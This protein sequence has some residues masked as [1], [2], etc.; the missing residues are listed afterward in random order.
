MEGTIAEHRGD[1]YFFRA[2]AAVLLL[3]KG[4]SLRS[5]LLLAV[6]V[7]TTWSLPAAV[8]FQPA[9]DNAVWLEEDVIKIYPNA[10]LIRRDEYTARPGVFEISKSLPSEATEIWVEQQ[11]DWMESV[12]PPYAATLPK[13]GNTE[14]KL[15]EVTGSAQVAWL[16]NP[17]KFVAAKDGQVSPKGYLIKTGPDASVACMLGG[18]NSCRFAPNSEGQVVQELV[19]SQR[20]TTITMKS[21]TVFSKVGRKTGETQSYK[22]VTSFGTAAA[23]GTD[24]VAVTLPDRL[25]VWIAQGTVEL[26]NAEGQSLGTVS[27]TGS[28][29][30]IIRT[31]RYDTAQ[32]D[33]LAN[34]QTMGAAAA[35]LPKLNLKTA[36]LRQKQIDGQTL[37]PEETAF[38]ARLQ[39][40]R[41]FVRAQ[42]YRAPAAEDPEIKLPAQKDSAADPTGPAT[43]P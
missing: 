11:G 14:I 27:A 26:T 4:M 22:V 12:T 32:A 15:V 13:V 35:M 37:T 9:A 39:T 1:A 17:K 24:F 29:L 16:K 41:W 28:G 43:T 42:P 30:K 2:K 6:L 31:S 5:H 8:L 3:N 38:L 25:D 34:S 23:K 18:V 7:L 33:A 20:Q 36:L 10:V 21:G 40:F 19:G